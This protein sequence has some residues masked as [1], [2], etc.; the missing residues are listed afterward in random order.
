[1][2]AAIADPV[3]ALDFDLAAH[4]ACEGAERDRLR[5]MSRQGVDAEGAAAGNTV[6]W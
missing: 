3:L 5:E 4:L 2:L 1:V 6:F